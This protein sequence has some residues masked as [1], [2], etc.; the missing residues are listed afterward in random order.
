VAKRA[1]QI[2][3]IRSLLTEGGVEI[4][5]APTEAAGHATEIA[6]Q[7]AASGTVDS[8]LVFGGDGTLREAA[9]GLLDTPVALAPLSA[10]TT[11]VVTRNL[12]LPVDPRKAASKLLDAEPI[13]SDVGLCNDEPFLILASFGI[14]AA[15][16]RDVSTRFKNVAGRGAV[17]ATGL[18]SLWQYDYPVTAYTVDGEEGWGTFVAACNISHY[19]G[20]FLLAP[21]AS[22]VDHNLHLVSFRG[23]GRTGILRFALALVLGASHVRLR[24]AET[25]IFEELVVPGPRMAPLQ[26]DGDFVDLEPPFRIRM[27]EQNVRLLVPRRTP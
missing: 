22:F 17:I 25:R 13:T 16:M 14:D 7:A 19:G 5:T 23:R 3:Q 6:R 4:D 12:G 11:N 21:D 18:R 20:D 1:Q 24:D 2:E 26:L 9:R 10:G 15:I 27:S 8:I